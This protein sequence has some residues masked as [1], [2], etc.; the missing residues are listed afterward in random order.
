MRPRDPRAHAAVISFLISTTFLRSTRFLA[1]ASLSWIRRVDLF[2]TLQVDNRVLLR[3]PD[4]GVA[5]DIAGLDARPADLLSPS[6]V[7]AP[8]GV[9]PQAGEI[10]AFSLGGR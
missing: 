3:H 9:R 5:G 6:D 10:A 4:G 1:F 2:L 7:C 8:E